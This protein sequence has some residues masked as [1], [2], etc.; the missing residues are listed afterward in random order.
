M[1][2]RIDIGNDARLVVFSG[3]RVVVNAQFYGHT[4]LKTTDLNGDGVDEFLLY[5]GATGAGGELSSSAELV[6]VKGRRFRT[7]KN[8]GEVEHQ[9]RCFGE[10]DA[11]GSEN[12][13]SIIYYIPSKVKG[14]FPRFRVDFYRCKCPDEFDMT[15]PQTCKYVQSGKIPEE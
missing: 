6:E 11:P 1:Q 13:T 5:S 10:E 8:F 2:T 4:I 9:F 7:I 15:N 12:I 14:T 3:E